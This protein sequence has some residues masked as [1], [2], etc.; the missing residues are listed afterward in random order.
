MFIGDAHVYSNQQEAINE[1]VQNEV[2]PFPV[3]EILATHEKKITDIQYGD[4]KLHNY[5]SGNAISVPMAI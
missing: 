5:L 3:L 4:V 2:M 1:M